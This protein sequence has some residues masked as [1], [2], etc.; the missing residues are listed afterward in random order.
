M[1]LA[2]LRLD[3]WY[4]KSTRQWIVTLKD[5][6]DNQV[7]DAIFVALSTEAARI[8]KDHPG[9]NLPKPDD[10][11]YGFN[12]PQEYKP[13]QRALLRLLEAGEIQV[14]DVAT[15]KLMFTIRDL[16]SSVS[17]LIVDVS[18][19][20]GACGVFPLLKSVEARKARL[21]NGTREVTW[22]QLKSGLVK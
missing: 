3:R 1:N 5:K 12:M 15:R 16:Y 11:R 2:D 9:F 7:G 14:W 8:G 17:M 22:R 18:G 13:A 4:D 6:E 19:K 10:D 21:W 20:R